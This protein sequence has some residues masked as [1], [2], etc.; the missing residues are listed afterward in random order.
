M[1]ERQTAQ[2]TQGPPT[3]ADEVLLRSFVES[4]D[5]NSFEILVR[6]YQHEIYNYLRRYL[7]DDDQAEDAFQLTFVQV[8]RKAQQFD[9]ERRFRP[10]LYSVAT[11]QAI[12][13]QRRVKRRHYLSLDVPAAGDNSRGTTQ[14]ASIP[15]YRAAD[16]DLLERAELQSRIRDAIDEVGEPGRSALQLVHLQ[17]LAYRDAAEI[18][19]V[20]V[21]T[22][23]SRV[24]AAIRKLSAIWQRNEEGTR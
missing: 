18:L 6:R 4:G 21:G 22:V 13:L 15:D 1:L 20:P 3:L 7:G 8:Y 5:R 11:N 16:D 17:G 19:G 23:K 2:L 10:W 12:D 14:A 24:H 9:L